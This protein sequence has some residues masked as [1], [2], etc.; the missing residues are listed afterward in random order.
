MTTMDKELSMDDVVDFVE[1]NIDE[2][3]SECMTTM[4][5][6]LYK[7]ILLNRLAILESAGDS[8]SRAAI[9]HN[10]RLINELNRKLMEQVD[11]E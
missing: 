6:F 10:E 3:P 5:Y 4:F 9:E 11:D 7:E 8:Q 2:S 1:I